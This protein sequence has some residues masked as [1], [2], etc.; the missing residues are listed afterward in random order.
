M[1]PLTE[2]ISGTL[3]LP[4]K[5]AATDWASVLSPSGVPV[6]WHSRYSMAAGSIPAS[7]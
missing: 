6:A 5:N 7:A 1:L 3:P 2:P 4:P